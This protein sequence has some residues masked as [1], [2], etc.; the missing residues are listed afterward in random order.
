MAEK[1][2]DEYMLALAEDDKKHKELFKKNADIVLDIANRIVSLEPILER[3]EKNLL[4]KTGIDR[5][6]EENFIQ[7]LKYRIL[8]YKTI[9]LESDNLHIYDSIKRVKELMKDGSKIL[10]R[11]K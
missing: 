1:K 6:D 2:L 5:I 7:A 9:L 4:K 3:A 11:R 10:L 8:H